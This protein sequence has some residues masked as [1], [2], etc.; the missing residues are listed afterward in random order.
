MKQIILPTDFSDNAWKAMSYAADLYHDI[1]CQFHILNTYSPATL[2][3]EPGV[4]IPVESLG[5]ESEEKLEG[6]LKQFKDLEHHDLSEFETKSSCGSFVDIMSYLEEDLENPIIVMGTKG[7]SGIGDFIFGTMTTN[8]I[9]KCS[10]PI[11]CVPNIANLHTPKKIMFAMDDHLISSEAEISPLLELAEKWESKISTI[12][13]NEKKRTK[14]EK[15]V[16]EIV[17]DHFFKHIQHSYHTTIPGSNVED[18]LLQFAKV[19][20]IDLITMIKRDKDFW[21]RFFETSL[22]QNMAFYSQLPLLILREQ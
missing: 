19:N 14:N 7:V 1:P 11:I 16:K 20:Q 4:M 21:K 18:E 2:Y 22:T 17:A 5:A 9:N 6:L 12:H 15:T 10:S 13:I 8:A 3:P